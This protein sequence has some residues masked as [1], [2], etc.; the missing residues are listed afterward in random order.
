MAQGRDVGPDA[1]PLTATVGEQLRE[2]AETERAAEV[3]RQDAERVHAR[4]EAHKA[5]EQASVER[6][7]AAPPRP[8]GDRV[9]L[10]ATEALR[11]SSRV[12]PALVLGVAAV[13]LLGRGWVRGVALVA[14]AI[15]VAR[16]LSARA[17]VPA[18]AGGA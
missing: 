12:T 17:R 13:A 3:E 1:A 7:L 8:V 5:D 18:E 14:S 10:P 4:M 15:Y 9:A 11:A 2:K 16:A 6:H